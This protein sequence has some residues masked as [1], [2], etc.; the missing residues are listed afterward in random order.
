MTAKTDVEDGSR[1]YLY[2]LGAS[3]STKKVRCTVPWELNE[4]TI[5]FGPCKKRIRVRLRR[6]YLDNNL[7]YARVQEKVYLAAFNA[8]T[9]G[10]KHLM[11]AG[12]VREI[13]TFSQAYKR[14]TEQKDDLD[15]EDM[16]IHPCSPIHVKPVPADDGPVEGYLHI[17]EEHTENNDWIMDLVGFRRPKHAKRNGKTLWRREKGDHFKAFPRD[18]CMVLDNIFFASNGGIPLDYDG[19]NT[20]RDFQTKDMNEA[21][22]QRIGDTIQV[23]SPFGRTA[24]DAVEGLRGRHLEMTGKHADRFIAWVKEGAKKIPSRKKGRSSRSD[25]SLRLCS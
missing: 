2:V 3:T 13:M 5:F 11:W 10:P 17:S 23:E 24:T 8:G 12:R 7:N 21:D 1:L 25:G 4:S 9:N 14:F 15:V 6:K 19:V 18:A 22:K 20:L 16:L